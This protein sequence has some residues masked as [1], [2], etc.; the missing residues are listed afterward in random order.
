MKIDANV[1]I[2]FHTDPL[3]CGWLYAKRRPPSCW[4]RSRRGSAARRRPARSAACAGSPCWRRLWNRSV[5][6]GCPPSRPAARPAPPWRWPAERRPAADRRPSR[7]AAAPT[8]LWWIRTRW[9]TQYN[10][11]LCKYG[12]TRRFSDFCSSIGAEKAAHLWVIC[13]MRL[14]SPESTHSINS[15]AL[16]G[17]AETRSSRITWFGWRKHV[18]TWTSTWTQPLLCQFYLCA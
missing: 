14:S 15:S 11:T 18:E 12:F 8:P 3:T 9:G 16:M 10:L 7:S 13:W 17:G 6:W 2:D 5:R 4:R 1:D